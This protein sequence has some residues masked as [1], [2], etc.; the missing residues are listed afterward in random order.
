MLRIRGIAK[1]STENKLAKESV[2]APNKNNIIKS[3]RLI[4]IA[5]THEILSSL[6][7]RMSDSNMLGETFQRNKFVIEGT[8]DL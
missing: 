1:C 6:I 4:P 5:T 3:T 8:I 2:I 7:L